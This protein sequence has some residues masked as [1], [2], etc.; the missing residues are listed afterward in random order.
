MGFFL[1]LTLLTLLT[2]LALLSPVSLLK[3][4]ALLTLT[5]L[6]TLFYFDCFGHQELKN[7][8]HDGLW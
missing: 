8:V 3:P 7:I 6:N 4:L 1:E 2:L 5:P